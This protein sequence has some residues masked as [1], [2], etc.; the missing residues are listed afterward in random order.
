MGG[1]IIALVIAVVM[2]WA[3]IWLWKVI[4][5]S[6]TGGKHKNK[7]ITFMSSQNVQ[8]IANQ[9]RKVAAELGAQV[10][11]IEDND[12]LGNQGAQ[13]D[14]AVVLSGGNK[15]MGFKPWAVQ[16]YV[17]NAG[18]KSR[19]ELVALSSS[20][21]MASFGMKM[22]TSMKYLDIIANRIK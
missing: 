13:E 3:V 12:P 17:Q 19:V 5:N 7:N 8:S 11:K 22:E 15:G 1:M 2:L 6:A 10:E 4:I 21:T 16:V 9:L 20:T 14:I 18:D